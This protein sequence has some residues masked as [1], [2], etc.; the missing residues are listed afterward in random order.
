MVTN[1][2][3][4]YRS[5]IA[6]GNEISNVKVKRF[7]TKKAAENYVK[8]NKPCL[9]LQEVTE[10][11]YKLYDES[12]KVNYKGYYNELTKIVKQKLK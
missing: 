1:D 4:D 3:F 8:M 2:L 12:M 5:L 6:M 9:S 11:W 10:L 7:S